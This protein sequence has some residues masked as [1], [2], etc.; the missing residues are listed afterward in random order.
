MEYLFAY[1]T[2]QSDSVQIS[3]FGRKLEGVPDALPV[4]KIITITIDD[5]DFVAT[6]G[7]A[8]HRNLQFTG[9][10]SDVVE[11][12][13]F[14]MSAEELEQADSYEPDGYA[15]QLVQLRSGIKAW[16]YLARQQANE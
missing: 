14:K 5:Q 16:V 3:T 8:H 2:L 11:G 10:A 13:V 6:S 4:Y 15:R 7:A 1:G 12:T 9:D